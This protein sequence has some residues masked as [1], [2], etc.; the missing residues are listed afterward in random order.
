MLRLDPAA[1][2]PVHQR[3]EIRNIVVIRECSPGE[4]K[5]SARG[6]VVPETVVKV[7]STREVHFPRIRLKAGRVVERRLSQLET[8]RGVVEPV[9]IQVH[10]HSE[11]QAT[12]YQE[13][14]VARH[15]F[16]QQPLCAQKVLL[17]LGIVRVDLFK[18]FACKKR[19]FASKSVVGGCDMA[20]FSRGEIF[21]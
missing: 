2:A 4:F 15:G 10:V 9:P 13:L 19:R 18:S 21:A 20:A 6:I 8:R 1:L 7:I 3:R 5:L 16:I 11:E 14:R 12:S 17:S